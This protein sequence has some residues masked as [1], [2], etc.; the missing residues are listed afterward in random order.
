MEIIRPSDHQLILKTYGNM[1]KVLREFAV[2]APLLI[3]VAFVF[4]L[5]LRI[6]FPEYLDI[7]TCLLIALFPYVGAGC[8]GI[9]TTRDHIA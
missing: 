1:R 3:V 2:I 8:V 5:I 9:A 4:V 7:S 6:A